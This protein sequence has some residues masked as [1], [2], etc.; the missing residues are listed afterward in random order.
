MSAETTPVEPRPPT[1][2]DAFHIWSVEQ[3]NESLSSDLKVLLWLQSLPRVATTHLRIR[4]LGSR[5][6]ITHDGPGARGTLVLPQL[7]MRLQTTLLNF[8]VSREPLQAE[9]RPRLWNEALIT[10]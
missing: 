10:P 8:I 2:L 7:S 9:A 4:Y 3:E 5:F 1:M 6:S